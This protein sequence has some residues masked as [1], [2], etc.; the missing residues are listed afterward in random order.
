MSPSFSTNNGVRYRFYVSS[1][2][3]R[4]RK[5]EAGS[6]RRVAAQAIEDAV[7]QAVRN[8]FPTDEP[9]DD[10]QLLGRHTDINVP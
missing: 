8:H 6:V 7:V 5:A 4:G 1:A 9:I 3:L 10:L 2:L